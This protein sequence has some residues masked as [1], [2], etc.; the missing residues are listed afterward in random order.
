MHGAT[1]LSLLLLGFQDLPPLDVHAAIQNS[2]E[3]NLADWNA[4]PEYSYEETDRLAHGSKTYGVRMI[5]GSPYRRLI[6]VDGEPLAPDDQHKQLRLL[7]AAIQSRRAE[8][9]SERSARIAEYTQERRRDR[10]LMSQLAEA[11]TFTFRGEETVNGH[12]TYVLKAT[13]RPDYRPPNL[14]AEVLKGMEGTVWLDQDSFQWVKVEAEVVHPVS[15]A[16]FLARI[17]P[18][19]RFEL[20]NA[21]VSEGIWM[22]AHFSMTAHAKILYV[23]SHNPKVDETYFGYRKAEPVP[24]DGSKAQFGAGIP[25]LAR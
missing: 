10:L 1:I 11:F 2:V 25:R 4:A 19:T 16:G 24:A 7:K 13:R 5:L 6:A 20:E 18:G 14:Q 21:P 3:T 17:E 9:S 15:I 8:S 22:P 23:F 12:N